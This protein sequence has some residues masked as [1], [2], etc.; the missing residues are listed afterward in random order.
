MVRSPGL[1]RFRVSQSRPTGTR[2]GIPLSL[3]VR[4]RVGAQTRRKVPR[5]W[6][7]WST[8]SVP[9]SVLLK[10]R[11]LGTAKIIFTVFAAFL[12]L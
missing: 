8:A 3:R 11:L 9:G 5:A 12:K 1:G 2:A 4:P 6:T 7:Y 10:G